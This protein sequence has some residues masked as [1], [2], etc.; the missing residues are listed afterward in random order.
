MVSEIANP[1]NILFNLL[2]MPWKEYRPRT[3]RLSILP[4][5]PRVSGTLTATETLKNISLQKEMKIGNNLR[6]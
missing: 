2:L 4:N 3:Q 1:L 5:I 6:A